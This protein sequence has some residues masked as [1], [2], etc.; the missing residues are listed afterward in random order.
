MRVA[1]VTF[2]Q[3]GQAVLHEFSGVH[4]VVGEQDELLHAVGG[5][6][7]VVFDTLAGHIEAVRREVKKRQFITVEGIPGA[8]DNAVINEVKARLRDCRVPRVTSR[9]SPNA[10]NVLWGVF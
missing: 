5:D 9:R 6:A 10:T 2:H 8:V 3:F 4:G 7:G 1:G